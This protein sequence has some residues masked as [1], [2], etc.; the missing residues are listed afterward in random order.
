MPTI[1]HRAGNLVE[2]FHDHEV[3]QA[4]VSEL[5]SM[6]FRDSQIE[7]AFVDREI[8]EEAETEDV[9]ELLKFLSAAG[10]GVVGL[11]GLGIVSGIVPAIAGGTIGIIIS[12]AVAA[13]TVGGAGT[14]IELRGPRKG[15]DDEVKSGLIVVTVKAGPRDEIACSVLNRFNGSAERAALQAT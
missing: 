11:V 2:V 8:L 6:G 14:F 12:S 5:K 3:A 13:A 15:L 10:L 9:I 4:A 1:S 7:V